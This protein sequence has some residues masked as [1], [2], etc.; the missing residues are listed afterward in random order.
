MCNREISLSER[1]KLQFYPLGD[2]HIGSPQF[3]EEFLEFWKK[4]FLGSS[5]EKIIYLQGD[6]L[7]CATKRLGNS[8]Y[9]QT[10]SIDEQVEYIIKF[11]FFNYLRILYLF[12]H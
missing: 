8:S 7:D 12:I 9:K 5:S 2:I 4:T 3:N 1:K 6:L 11:H 10:M